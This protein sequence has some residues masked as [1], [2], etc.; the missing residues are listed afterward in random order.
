MDP[1]IS[2]LAHYVQ[3]YGLYALLVATSASLVFGVAAIFEPKRL[4]A[5]SARRANSMEWAVTGISNKFVPEDKRE[6][7][8][9]GLHLLQAG[10]EAPNSVQVYFGIRIILAIA[11]PGALLFALPVLGLPLKS[12]IF[13]GLLA[14]IFGFLVPAYWVRARRSRRQRKFRD[15]LP[16]VLDLLLVCSEAGLG[17][18][19]AL[20]KV[21]E[22]M[23]EPHPLLAL[24]LQRISTEL[25]AGMVRAEAMRNFSR[26]TGID[27]TISLVN[28][29]VQ[30]DALGTSIA[31]TLRAFAEDM[32]ARRML[33]AEEMGH[34]AGAKLTVI[35]VA[36]FLPAIFAA[37]LA[38]TIFS[39]LTKMQGLSVTTPWH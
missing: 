35:L 1:Y 20:L 4:A 34:K 10:Y 2:L 27:E 24:E 32:R 23:A 28:L 15:G 29:L 21:G 12:S 22:E 3:S 6:R 38:P 16:D 11:I 39:A 9:L 5:L 18:D 8:T 36:C 17:L 13:A 37:I 19:M 26:R 31:D 30:S 7:D 14:A 33:R 25:R